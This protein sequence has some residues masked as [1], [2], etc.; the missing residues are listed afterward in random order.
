MD[1][2]F[3]WYNIPKNIPNEL[4]KYTKGPKRI[5]NGK[6]EYQLSAKYV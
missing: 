3:S 5:Q 6:N 4:A 2:D 1:R